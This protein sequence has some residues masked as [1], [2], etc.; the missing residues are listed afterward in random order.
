M[1]DCQRSDTWL[2]PIA[3]GSG[4]PTQRNFKDQMNPKKSALIPDPLIVP[5][6]CVWTMKPFQAIQSFSG[7]TLSLKGVGLALSLLPTVSSMR[8]TPT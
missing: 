4:T 2:W 1:S 7:R 8:P 6:R 5:V 3:G